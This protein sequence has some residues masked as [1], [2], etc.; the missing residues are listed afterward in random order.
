MRPRLRERFVFM[1][2]VVMSLGVCLGLTACGS[3]DDAGAIKTLSWTAVA[4][5]SVLG[6]KVYWGTESRSYEGNADAGPN[7][8]YTVKGLTPGQTYFFAVSAYNSEG[9]SALSA[10]VSSLAESD[11]SRLRTEGK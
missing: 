10:E 6:Y 11:W 5:S 7:P 1:P 8:T 4:D 9:E 2:M 3:D